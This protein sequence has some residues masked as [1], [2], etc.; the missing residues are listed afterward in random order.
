MKDETC[1]NDP[2]LIPAG[3]GPCNTMLSKVFW[4]C[5]I[6]EWSCYQC[7]KKFE[8]RQSLKI[9]IMDKHVTKVQFD[10]CDHKVPRG[11]MSIC[12]I[13]KQKIFSGSTTTSSRYRL[14]LTCVSMICVCPLELCYN[15]Q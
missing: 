11:R 15:L 9:N 7:P 3:S 14:Y 5:L 12:L 1:F 4:A 6:N 10:F 13:K 8:K 2:P